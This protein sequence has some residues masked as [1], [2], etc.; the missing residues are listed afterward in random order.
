MY[1]VLRSIGVGLSFLLT[2]AAALLALFL[3]IGLLTPGGW[4]ALLFVGL[5]IWFTLTRLRSRRVTAILE[6][7]R[8]AFR[9]NLPLPG[10]LAAAAAS[11]TGS[12]RDRLGDLAN[13][14]GRGAPLADALD[15]DVPEMAARERGVLRAAEASGR[16]PQALDRLVG[17]R[18]NRQRTEDADVSYVLAYPAFMLVV[19]AC[20]TS[21]LLVA[22]MPKFVRIMQD[23]GGTL[24][25]PTRALAGVGQWLAGPLLDY[26][27]VNKGVPGLVWIGLVL[28][29]AVGLAVAA[30][31]RRDGPIIQ[32]LRWNLPLVHALERDRGM[33]DL[34]HALAEAT[35]AGLPIDQALT[36]AGALRLNAVLA[37]RVT[38]W[39]KAVQ[40]GSPLS[41]AA[42]AARLPAMFV[43]V[44]ASGQA[45]ADLAPMFRFLNR[46]YDMQFSRTA[47]VL[48]GAAVPAMV[49]TFGS[50]VAWI[51]VSMILPLVA[52]MHA[53][54]PQWGPP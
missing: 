26:N 31:L 15:R 6:H 51:A 22:V 25:A 28:L 5:M 9:L 14:V 38:Q 45:G 8:A 12:L 13:S 10:T 41:D 18:R 49:L 3:G 19:L 4:P 21:F 7:L 50:M 47:A 42:R 44:L 35:D 52:I 29:A 40:A 17:Q 53:A 43:G 24:P 20:V 33:G 1:R 16:L 32:T 37:R 27:P 2:A 54:G 48:R 30:W 11:E 39:A 46:H 23:F 36:Q 34:C